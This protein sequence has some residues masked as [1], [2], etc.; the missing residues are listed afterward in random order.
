MRLPP[1]SG[2]KVIHQRSIFGYADIAPD[3]RGE[4]VRPANLTADARTY[5]SAPTLTAAVLN[6]C[7]AQSP[8]CCRR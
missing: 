2:E 7:S 6:V 8:R 5:T 3:E 4:I 1:C